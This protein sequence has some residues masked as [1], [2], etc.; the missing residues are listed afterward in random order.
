[1]WRD[2]FLATG[3]GNVAR[4]KVVEKKIATEQLLARTLQVW[5]ARFWK[6]P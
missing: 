4:E 2:L 5:A 6:V 1:M 3:E